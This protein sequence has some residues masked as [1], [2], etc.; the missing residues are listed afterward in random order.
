[1]CADAYAGCLGLLQTALS[2]PHSP[3]PWIIHSHVGT[4]WCPSLP[5]AETAGIVLE[6]NMGL[7]EPNIMFLALLAFGG[8]LESECMG[9]T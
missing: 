6:D 3:E 2:M 8:N 4:L 1:M 5:S 7:G 9:C